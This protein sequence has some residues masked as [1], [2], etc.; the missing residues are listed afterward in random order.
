MAE[1]GVLSA[2]QQRP[3]RPVLRQGRKVADRVDT[4]VDGDEAA[5]LDAPL[6]A[7]R[8]DTESEQLR[9]LYIASLAPGQRRDLSVD[10]L[11]HAESDGFFL[12]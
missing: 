11:I 5:E 6:Y 9:A 8:A 1:N 4:G 7:L 2:G 3:D 10:G 12:G